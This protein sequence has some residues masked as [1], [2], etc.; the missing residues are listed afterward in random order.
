MYASITSMKPEDI[1]HLAK[2]SRIEI[3]DEQLPTFQKEFTEI[4]AFVDQV[5]KLAGETV[6]PPLPEWRNVMRDDAYPN[7][8]GQYTD[9]LLAN[10][11]E[12]ED[13]YLV[14]KKIL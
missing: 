13:N 14:V 3:S 8:P 6:V 10:A 5:K 4:L 1:K 9:D 12:H 7:T 11:P 2:L